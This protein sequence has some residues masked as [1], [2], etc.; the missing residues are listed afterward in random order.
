MFADVFAFL[1][2]ARLRLTLEV[3]GTPA[4]LGWNATKRPHAVTADAW[5][6]ADRRGQL[7]MLPYQIDRGPRWSTR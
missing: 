7:V 2:A 4:G 1:P 6:L 3:P 5:M